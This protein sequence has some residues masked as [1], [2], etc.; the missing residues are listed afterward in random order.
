MPM[1]TQIRRFIHRDD[2][3]FESYLRREEKYRRRC[4]PGARSDHGPDA[5]R[6]K[7]EIFRAGL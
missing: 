7:Y 1:L 2:R 3:D 4:G 5:D 6:L